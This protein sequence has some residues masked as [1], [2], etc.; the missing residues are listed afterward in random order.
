MLNVNISR[1]N[2]PLCIRYVATR[3]PW[4]RIVHDCDF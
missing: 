2:L 4:T 1:W 3:S